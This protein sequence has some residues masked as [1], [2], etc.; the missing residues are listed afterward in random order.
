MNAGMT[1]RNVM[2]TE[3][4]KNLGIE[5][6]SHGIVDLVHQNQPPIPSYSKEIIHIADS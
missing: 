5:L 4:I 1:T 6:S 2:S 3:G